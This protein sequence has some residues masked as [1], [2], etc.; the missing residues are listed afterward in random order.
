MFFTPWLLFLSSLV[1]LPLSMPALASTPC[2]NSPA[3][4]L[5]LL[6]VVRSLDEM[7]DQGDFERAAQLIADDAVISTPFGKKTKEQFLQT[8]QGRS[9]PVWS[10]T[11]VGDD[12]RQCI[13]QGTRKLGFLSIKVKRIIEINSE[14][15]IDKI[16]VT[17][18]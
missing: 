6:D 7:I 14:N 11:R 5:L 2:Q 17:K 15:K 16:A 12:E 3:L 9:R 8:L 4:L 1:Y 18:Q 10:A 13:S